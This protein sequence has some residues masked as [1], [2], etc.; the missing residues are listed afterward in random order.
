MA[1]TGIYQIVNTVNG[2]KY[3]GSAVNLGKRKTNHFS[4]LEKETHPNSHLQSAYNKYGVGAFVFEELITVPSNWLI[5]VEQLFLDWLRPEYNKRI[6][7]N[8]N[9]G[10]SPSAET[11]RKIGEASKGNT[12]ALGRKHTDEERRK[13]SLGNKGKTISAEQRRKLSISNMGNTSSK[14][15]ILSPEHKKRISAALMGNV[16]SLGS[17]CSPENKQKLSDLKK[18]RPNFG[19]HTRWHTNRGMVSPACKFCGGE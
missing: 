7:A 1:Q 8:S 15:R 11:R 12:Y 3:I 13:I 19:S 6:I 18:D 2:K 5:I 17:I 14:G 9:L 10:L 4:K 16:N